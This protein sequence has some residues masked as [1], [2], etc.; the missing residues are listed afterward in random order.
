MAGL[1][2][3]Q[4]ALPP[5]CAQQLAPLA[6]QAALDK[7]PHVLNEYFSNSVQLYSLYRFLQT[8]RHCNQ[9]LRLYR[10]SLALHED[11]LRIGTYCPLHLHALMLSWA[12]SADERVLG[13]HAR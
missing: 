5:V 8:C 10:T 1:A 6:R 2:L 3:L 4:G 7:A 9:Q 11:C 12:V 13:Q